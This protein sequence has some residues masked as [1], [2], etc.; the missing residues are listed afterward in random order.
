MI[1]L[2][3]FVTLIKGVCKEGL[4]FQI[5]RYPAKIAIMKTPKFSMK[6]RSVTNPSTIAIANVMISVMSAFPKLVLFMK[7]LSKKYGKM[8]I[9]KKKYE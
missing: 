6:S 5:T 1:P 9:N 7:K 2:I 4:T 3:A 8:R